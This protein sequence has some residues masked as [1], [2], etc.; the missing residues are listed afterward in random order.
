M[1]VSGNFSN[2][3]YKLIRI[4][5]RLKCVKIQLFSGLYL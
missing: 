2:S 5:G 3:N 4:K 1:G